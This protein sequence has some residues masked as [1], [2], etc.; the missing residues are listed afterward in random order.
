MIDIVD[1]RCSIAKYRRGVGIDGRRTRRGVTTSE[2]SV[3]DVDACKIQTVPAGVVLITHGMEVCCRYVVTNF[4]AVTIDGD[5]RQYLAL[6]L[7]QYLTVLGQHE[8]VM[9]HN[10]FW[11]VLVIDEISWNVRYIILRG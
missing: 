7:N 8:F 5:S 3:E 6:R 11:V 1:R 2:Y 10:P 4:V 9:V